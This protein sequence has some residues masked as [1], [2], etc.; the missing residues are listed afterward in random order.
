MTGAL[1]EVGTPDTITTASDGEGAC[2]ENEGAA[3]FAL[4]STTSVRV[5]A[6]TFPAA[7]RKRACT[8]FSPSEDVAP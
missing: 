4:S 7:S 6:E 8:A 2:A 3:G 1:S 5:V